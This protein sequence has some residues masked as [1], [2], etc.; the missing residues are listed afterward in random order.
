MTSSIVVDFFTFIWTLEIKVCAEKEIYTLR[1]YDKQYN[2]L[3]RI[4]R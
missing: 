2:R 1:G 4:V 3:E